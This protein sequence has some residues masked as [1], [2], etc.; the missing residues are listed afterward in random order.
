MTFDPIANGDSDEVVILGE[1]A[2]WIMLDRDEGGE[3]R[4]HFVAPCLDVGPPDVT[5]FATPTGSTVVGYF[6]ANPEV[7]W[8]DELDA[9]V[10]TSDNGSGHPWVWLAVTSEGGFRFYVPSRHLARSVREQVVHAAPTGE[11]KMGM[12][13]P[14]DAAMR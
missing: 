4:A 5:V 14:V 8:G 3:M 2:P 1:G 13:L 9:S 10:D 11:T 12:Y 6:F 7:E